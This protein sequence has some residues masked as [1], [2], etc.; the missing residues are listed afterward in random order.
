ML[1]MFPYY[2]NDRIRY[3]EKERRNPDFI[4]GI[5]QLLGIEPGYR[6]HDDAPDADERAIADLAEFD[7]AYTSPP[8]IGQ[9]SHADFN[10]KY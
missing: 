3:N 8:I 1:S 2:E 7:R 9:A 5:R 10:S 4:E 6:T